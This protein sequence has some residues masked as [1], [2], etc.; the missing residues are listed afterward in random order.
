MAWET[1]QPG[2]DPMHDR[3]LACGQRQLQLQP[4]DPHL[5]DVEGTTPVDLQVE[6]SDRD[7]RRA[8]FGG[9]GE[10]DPDAPCHQEPPDTVLHGRSEAI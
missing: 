8:V 1:R 9:P 2:R 7:C 4:F 3:G 5:S 10:Q 6:D